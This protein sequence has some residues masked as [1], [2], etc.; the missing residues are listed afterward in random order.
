[1]YKCISVIIPTHNRPLQLLRA[2]KSLISS[3]YKNFE[4]VV[5]DDSTK[6]YADKNRDIIDALSKNLDIQY[7][8]IEPATVGRARNLGIRK[9]TGEVICFLDDDDWWHSKKLEFQIPKL[10][11]G[12]K[13]VFTGY[14]K[15]YFDTM[16]KKQK[17]L[18]QI[19]PREGHYSNLHAKLLN[20]EVIIPT[21]SVAIRREVL[22]EVG[23]FDENLPV[24]EDLDL[25]LR[26]TKTIGDNHVYAVGK[27]L[28]FSE[29]TP[30]S[31]SKN[32]LLQSI[33]LKT[34]CR[35]YGSI[36][37]TEKKLSIIQKISENLSIMG[38]KEEAFK[39]SR[40]ITPIIFEK[41]KQS[42]KSDR[43]LLIK[44]LIHNL[45]FIN[46][47]VIK[48]LWQINDRSSGVIKK[49]ISFIII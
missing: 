27:V 29:E 21:S 31:L 45:F 15:V 35:K 38:Y 46:S 43:E 4:V 22:E 18:Y 33:G 1:M 28:V 40:L 42:R 25:W 6:T 11:Q 49:L 3:S 37:K 26:I 14:A 17:L 34:F 20:G 16:S 2:L 5:V 48:L 47:Y 10:K 8:N 7:I 32:H 12:Y 23:G 9:S 39:I 19:V 41:M 30:S 44:I 13:L 36:L 24:L